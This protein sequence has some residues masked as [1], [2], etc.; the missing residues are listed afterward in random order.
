MRFHERHERGEALVLS[1]Q[2]PRG[3]RAPGDQ[4]ANGVHERRAQGGDEPIRGNDLEESRALLTRVHGELHRG[5]PTRR[6]GETHN[7]TQVKLY[8]L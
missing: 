5:T 2:D 7:Y 8:L 6:A 1:I 4:D 3:R